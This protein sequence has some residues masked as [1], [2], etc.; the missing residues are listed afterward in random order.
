MY[1]GGFH[2]EYH[3]FLS[4]KEEESDQIGWATYLYF[5]AMVLIAFSSVMAQLSDR[6]KHLEAY[7]YKSHFSP[8]Q[9][10]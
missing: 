5:T 1:A 4:A 10:Y 8:Y 7:T 2:S 6:R 9:S 3:I